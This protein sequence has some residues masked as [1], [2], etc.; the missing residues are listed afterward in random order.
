M[1][2][3]LESHCVRSLTA[4]DLSSLSTPQVL[5]FLMLPHYHYH[6]HHHYHYHY[7]HHYHYHYH[8]YR[9]FAPPLDI[10]PVF[11]L[12]IE[13]CCV[14]LHPLSTLS[15]LSTLQLRQPL[16]FTPCDSL[17]GNPRRNDHIATI[18]RSG[19]PWQKVTPDRIPPHPLPTRTSPGRKRLF[20]PAY[21]IALHLQQLASSGL[22]KTSR[23][24]AVFCPAARCIPNRLPPPTP[25]IS[26][27]V[28]L[29]ATLIVNTLLYPLPA[30]AL[31]PICAPADQDPAHHH[32]LCIKRPTNKLS[33][34]QIHLDTASHA[35]SW[36]SVVGRS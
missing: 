2:W 12:D 3:S 19:P 6:Y 15:T 1:D 22:Q 13:R 23:I 33:V 29:L 7:H 11:L 36:P 27:I 35:H 18:I 34:L 10:V 32:A 20:F 16:L 17:P 26:P 4:V 28:L 31:C 25:P 24:G 21:L 30:T 14:P 5:F 9:L 8:H